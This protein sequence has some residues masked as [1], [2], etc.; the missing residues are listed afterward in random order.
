MTDY[1]DIDQIDALL[2][3]QQ[4]IDQALTLLDDYDGTIPSVTIASADAAAPP[5]VA[6]N[7]TDPPQSMISGVRSGLIQRYNEINHELRD[8]GVTGPPVAETQPA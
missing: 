4:R 3:E 2:K 1:A 8:L 7:M 6:V 5:P